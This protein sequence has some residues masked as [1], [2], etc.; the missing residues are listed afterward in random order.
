MTSP[1]ETIADA[2]I[3]FILSLLRDPDAA[4][5]FASAPQGMLAANGLEGVCMADVAS[6]RPVLVD[7]PTVVRHDN[8]PPPPPGDDGDDGAVREIVR[9]IQ[10]YTTV[11]ARSTI[12]DQSVNQNIW[13]EGG[14]VTQLFDQDAVVAS[15]DGSLAAGDD[16][17]VVDSDVDVTIGDVAIGNE[18]NDGSFNQT[19]DGS[20]NQDGEDTDEIESADDAETDGQTADA[21]EGAGDAVSDETPAE[22]ADTATAALDQVVDTAAGAAQPAP[23]SAPPAPADVPEPADLL[24][25]DMTSGG[26]DSYEAD[27]SSAAMDDQPLDVPLEDD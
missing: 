14:D 22:A 13:T 15:G 1:V 4:E 21:T 3:A 17:A 6:I 18:T 9:M 27:A 25:G 24:E 5:D 10:Q 12:L 23:A 26:G 7:H 2:L 20:F 19:G 16:A 8:P 11:D